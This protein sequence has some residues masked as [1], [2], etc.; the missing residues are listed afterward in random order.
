MFFPT[1][2]AFIVGG[3]CFALRFRKDLRLPYDWQK[4]EE[5]GKSI[6]DQFLFWASW[7]A[8]GTLVV[9]YIIGGEKHWPISFIAGPVAIVMLALA[10]VRKTRRIRVILRSAPWHILIYALGMFVVITAAFNHGTLAFLTT[11]LHSMVAVNAGTWANLSAGGI[12]ALLAAAVNNLPATLIGVLVLRSVRAPSLM[13]I[14]AIILGVDIGPKFTPFGSL[15]TL[16]WLGILERQKIHISWGK[17]LKENW[18]VTLLVLCAALA[19]LVLSQM[20]WG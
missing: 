13:A 20:V 5:P 12:L 17:Y 7:V 8:L 9:G 18:W 11:P 1:L 19:G 2:A 15:A 10:K 4:L 6:T 16:L 3:L 14:S